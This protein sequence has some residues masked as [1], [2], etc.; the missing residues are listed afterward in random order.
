MKAVNPQLLMAGHASKNAASGVAATDAIGEGNSDFIGVFSGFVATSQHP[1]NPLS[2]DGEHAG[3]LFTSPNHTPV[4]EP[5]AKQGAT[6]Q[7]IDGGNAGGDL[8]LG[9][10]ASGKLLPIPAANKAAIGVGKLSTP[11][12]I[13]NSAKAPSPGG[14]G[15]PAVNHTTG[16]DQDQ[17]ASGRQPLTQNIALASSPGSVLRNSEFV[18][19]SSSEKSPQAG[20]KSLAG[21][22]SNVQTSVAAPLAGRDSA[23]ETSTDVSSPRGRAFPTNLCGGASPLAPLSVTS[24]FKILITAGNELVIYRYYQ[25]S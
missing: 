15:T 17:P 21:T 14:A 1:A 18:L 2:V 7:P 6:G 3:S 13:T 9:D 23:A 8:P 12:V 5:I 10:P 25:D 4:R 16:L 11:S 24:A 22:I 19:P 20:A